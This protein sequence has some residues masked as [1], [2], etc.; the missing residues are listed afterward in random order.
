MKR[1]N[2]ILLFAVIMFTAFISIVAIP[3]L[4]KFQKII[5][6]V[7]PIDVSK[8]KYLVVDGGFRV[9]I[10]SDERYSFLKNADLWGDINSQ[11]LIFEMN[12]DTLTIALKKGRDIYGLHSGG[13]IAFENS[14]IRYI[15][16]S[17]HA[18]VNYRNIL[19]DSMDISVNHGSSVYLQSEKEVKLYNVTAAEESFINIT[20]CRNAKV[21]LAG[22]TTAYIQLG[23]GEIS[24]ILKNTAVLELRGKG[25]NSKNLIKKDSSA[26]IYK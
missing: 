19:C 12:H 13:S 26:V 1:T 7:P 20:G 9:F 16:T 24:G 25:Y 17:H 11:N 2:N 14:N 3:K 22:K 5:Q 21:N 6:D 18:Y 4:I 10:Y 23:N 8:V 15:K